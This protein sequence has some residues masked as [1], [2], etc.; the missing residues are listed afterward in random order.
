M[1]RM[2]LTRKTFYS[3]SALLLMGGMLLQGC[4]ET[5]EPEVDPIPENPYTLSVVARKAEI[6]TKALDL[7][8]GTLHATW[9]AGEKV[10]VYNKTRNAGLEGY[11]EAQGS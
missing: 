4:G 3:I 1:L 8:Q 9:Q 7:N 6:G 10:T 2:M 11:L 5:I